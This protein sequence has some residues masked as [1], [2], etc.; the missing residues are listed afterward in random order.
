MNHRKTCSV[1]G[2]D[3]FMVTEVNWLTCQTKWCG[4]MVEITPTTCR[5]K[6]SEADRS[7]DDWNQEVI[8]RIVGDTQDPGWLY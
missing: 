4:A 5:T 7:F 3:R 1:C 8:D 2:G 6:P